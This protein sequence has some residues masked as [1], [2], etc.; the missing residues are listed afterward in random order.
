VAIVLGTF[1]Y[2]FIEQITGNMRNSLLAMMVFFAAGL[3]FL[4]L[5]KLPK[6]HQL[7]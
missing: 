2:G 7:I 3:I 1:S 4:T 6:N 5:A